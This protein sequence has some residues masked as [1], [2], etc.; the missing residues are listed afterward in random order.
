MFYK[1][2]TRALKKVYIQSKEDTI[3]DVVMR[4]RAISESFPVMKITD[5]HEFYDIDEKL[6]ILGL[7]IEKR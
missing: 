2:C 4:F 6:D 3:N 1:S 7:N 5:E